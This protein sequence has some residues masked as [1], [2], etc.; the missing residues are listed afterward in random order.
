LKNYYYGLIGVLFLCGIVMAISLSSGSAKI[1]KTHF[2]NGEIS[3][4][5]PSNWQQI[6]AQGS[7]VVAFQNPE[8]GLKIFINRQVPPNDWKAPENYTVTLSTLGEFGLKSISHDKID[9]NG[10]QAYKNIYQ[11]ESENKK[12]Q[13]MDIN[14][15]KNGAIYSIVVYTPPEAAENLLGGG[16]NTKKE[17]ETIMNSFTVHDFTIPTNATWG[18][19]S[20]PSQGVT[21]KTRSDTVNAEESVYK[22]PESFYPGNNGTLG[23][24]G[25]HTLHSAPFANINQLKVGEELIVKDYLTQKTYIYEVTSVGDINWEYKTNPVQFPAGTTQLTLVTCWPPGTTQAAFTVH[26][27]LKSIGPILN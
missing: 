7:Q 11:L 4:D 8:T 14:L 2:D 13:I 3:F 10:A 18:E 21:W 9:L 5:Y 6:N 19:I 1:E 16:T 24:L 26:A 12:I 22:Y 15:E 20:I 27:Q 17:I 23:F 25:H